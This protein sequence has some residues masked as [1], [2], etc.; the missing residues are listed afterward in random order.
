MIRPPS[1]S[2]T[3]SSACS[4]SIEDPGLVCEGTS[5]FFIQLVIDTMSL[6]FCGSISSLLRNN[7]QADRSIVD[8][9]GHNLAVF[10]NGW[11]V[12]NGSSQ[13]SACR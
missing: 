12:V 4:A 2:C 13:S 5:I 6:Y 11:A 3:L 9:H 8:D 1:I 10:I 7:V